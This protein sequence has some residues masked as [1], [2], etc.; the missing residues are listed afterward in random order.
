MRTTA[1]I[2]ARKGS[3]RIPGKMHQMIGN[4]TMLLRKVKQCLEIKGVEQVVVGSDDTSIAMEVDRLGA[5]FIEREE[6]FCDEKS[7]TVNEMIKDV[8]SK[9]TPITDQIL[10]AHPTNP[11]IESHHYQ[12]ALELLDAKRMLGYDSVF[13]V[14]RLQG[15]FWSNITTPINFSPISPIHI[16]AANLPPIFAQNGGIFIRPYNEMVQDGALIGKNALMIAMDQLDGW[17][18]DYPWQLEFAQYR[19]KAMAQAI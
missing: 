6:K 11:F 4:D 5:V 3:V 9:I 7:T 2:I 12:S 8:L 13:S 1:V 16:V 14:N 18:I 15:H 17:D 19:V 10:W